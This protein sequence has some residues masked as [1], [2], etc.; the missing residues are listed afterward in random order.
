MIRI[1][2]ADDHEMVRQGLA[3]IIEQH[4]DWRVCGEAATGR[5]AVELA[6]K[7][8]PNIVI[9]DLG[10]PEL[11]GLEAAR[12]IKKA[13]PNA[14]ILIFT[15]HDSTELT[16]EVIKAGA[17]GYILKEDAS[18]HIVRAIETL[19]DHKPYFTWKVSKTML[20]AYLRNGDPATGKL[21]QFNELTSR[22]REIIQLL[23]EGHSN[24]AVA[25]RLGISVKTVETHRA[26]IMR[27][28]S[29][30]SIAQMVR[31]AVRNHIIQP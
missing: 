29:I 20:D 19:A 6:N 13:L 8:V 3:K 12:Q 28:L 5:E 24:K 7:L 21:S 18:K 31:Y 4:A 15:M 14:E 23:A 2:L 30:S 17:R 9:L 11:N 10:M 25:T 27:K 16:H 1:L 22:E 26:A